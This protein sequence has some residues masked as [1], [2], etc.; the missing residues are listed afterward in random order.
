MVRHETGKD[1]IS[2][3]DDLRHHNRL[4]G[5]KSTYLSQHA[6]NPVDWYP[7]GKEA[8]RRAAD[9]N[10]PVFLSIGY[11]ACHWCHVMA[12]ESFENEDVARLLN[13]A[14]VCIK[15]DREERP[16]IDRVYMTACRMLS[17]T[18][19]WPLT[20]FLTPDKKP[21]F[22][23]T[24]L[25]RESRFGM[26]GLL[27]LLPRIANL[28]KERREELLD[29][30]ERISAALEDLARQNRCG[31]APGSELLDAAYEEL[32]MA[33][34]SENGGFG[35]P[36]KFPMPHSVMFLLR[37]WKRTGTAYALD[38]ATHT[39][40]RIRMG[41]IYDHLGGGVHRYSTD[42]A[43]RIPHFEKM[44]YDQAL[45][46]LAYTEAFLA[47]GIPCY[48]RTAEEILGY[49]L[50]EMTSPDGTF[51]S[52]EDADA[53]GREGGYYLWESSDLDHVLGSEDAALAR[54]VFNATKTGNFT[55]P[56]GTG[57]GNV[58]YRKDMADIPHGSFPVPAEEMA[59]RIETIRTS[60]FAAR[61][62][63]PRPLR[64]EMVLAD[65]NGLMIA[66]LAKAAQAFACPAYAKAAAKAAD[67]IL[68]QMR[69]PDGSL[70]H[71]YHTGE[72]AVL[73]FA[74]DYADMVYGLTMLYEAMFD[75]RYLT[76]ARDLISFLLAHFQDPDEGG[77]FT[78][79]D[80]GEHLLIRTTE[81]YDGAIP[82][83]NSVIFYNLLRL[84]RLTGD[85]V[86]HETA[87]KIPAAFSHALRS[88]PSAHAFFLC[89]LDYET[90]NPSEVVISG[91]RTNSDVQ[92]M[93]RV[94]S[95]GFFPSVTLTF[96]QEGYKPEKTPLPSLYGS[97]YPVIGGKATA[98]VCTGNTC[99]MPVTAP[100][101]LKK[102][103][104]GTG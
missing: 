9:E 88:A 10:R 24:Y 99:A 44:L 38:M 16:D 50:R 29:S 48:Q 56:H 102:V 42:S 55:D 23:A 86:Y 85:T 40:D 26:T 21:F 15:V 63:R 75:E 27:D 1:A 103:L 39:L 71:R 82:S 46:A 34:D 36:P 62:Q 100:D 90:G 76:A 81:I 2:G 18:G 45:L 77:F 32:V 47:T 70:F 8:F 25:P 52:A 12:R 5:E 14:F 92:D 20:I 68:S 61:Q 51:F 13:E 11:A 6:A 31:N 84:F 66:A 101:D 7:W 89:A 28:W 60:L 96:R 17:G 93:V 59:T 35:G 41:G 97:R 98:Y 58:L 49:V 33:F 74:D 80:N 19:G 79:P 4:A 22:A 54:V 64:N 30:S 3:K 104:T 72:A 95:T 73:G 94:V 65:W 37:Y 69:S 83:S 53:G 67:G 78:T 87:A 57:S 91:N 43:W